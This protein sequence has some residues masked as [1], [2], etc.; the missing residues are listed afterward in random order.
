MGLIRPPHYT[1]LMPTGWELT[2]AFF[3]MLFI[4]LF[5]GDGK[6]PVVELFSAISIVSLYIIVVLKGYAL[7]ALPQKL[8]FAWVAVILIQIVLIPFSDSAGYSVSAIVRTLQAFLVFSFFYSF[9][10]ER[11]LRWFSQCLLGTIFLTLLI[12]LYLSMNPL[13]ALKFPQMNL[14]YGFYGHNQIASLLIFIIPIVTERFLRKPGWMSLLFILFI[15]T[16]FLLTNARGA[17]LITFVY[18]LYKFVRSWQEDRLL[19]RLFLGT[20]CLIFL[21][22]FIIFTINPISLPQSLSSKLNRITFK[23]AAIWETRYHYWQQ[24]IKSIRDH[25]LLGSG[26]GTFYLQS[27]QYQQAPNSFSY[28]A[29]SFPLEN[30]V[31]LGIVGSIPFIILLS[32]LGKHWIR[33][34]RRHNEEVNHHTYIRSSLAWGALLTLTYSVI[35]FNLNF[36]VVW[37][38]FWAICGIH[39]GLVSKGKSDDILQIKLSL[40][41]FSVLIVFMFY[42]LSLGSILASQRNTSAGRKVAFIVAPYRL[43]QT[44]ELISSYRNQRLPLPPIYVKS[45]SFFHR[46]DPEIL[47]ELTTYHQQLADNNAAQKSYQTL[48][49]LD[50]KNWDLY[51]QYV[52]WMVELEFQSMIGQAV[53]TTSLHI[54]PKQFQAR[55]QLVDFTQP[56]LN[57]AFITNYQIFNEAATPI[58]LLQKLY[59]VSGLEVLAENPELTKRLWY[60]ARDIYPN[61][62]YYHIELAALEYHTLGDAEAAQNI[63]TECLVNRYAAYGCNLVI[64]SVI[65]V[66]GSQ[67]NSIQVIPRIL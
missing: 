33:D 40:V 44:I 36:L 42:I 51:R 43:D 49:D 52:N 56:A 7:R 13:Q 41:Q 6:Q 17:F 38:L 29:H 3:L 30:L 11:H 9:S 35:E 16:G 61:W 60:L 25:P 22:V 20:S 15:Y 54:L 4:S 67:K 2:L 14:L 63:L 62:G 48:F 57:K 55:L 39:F 34:I 53:K 21:T 18:L 28:Y 1:K 45:I 66:V 8:F 46:K 50:P 23:K 65:P 19:A 31:E 32:Y 27:K 47:Y 10:Q 12:A 59:Y 58:E 5:L 24:A 64:N 37:L 26:P